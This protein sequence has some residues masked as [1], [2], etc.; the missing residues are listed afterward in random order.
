MIPRSLYSAPHFLV[1]GL[2]NLLCT[3]LVI[4]ARPLPLYNGLGNLTSQWYLNYG[5]DEW[6]EATR[7]VSSPR[8]STALHTSFLGVV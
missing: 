6:R 2:H 4:G 7:S 5:E 8:P 1:S 3:C